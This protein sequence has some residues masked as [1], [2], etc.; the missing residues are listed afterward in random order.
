MRIA[1]V[2]TARASYAKFKTIITALVARDV[3]VQLVVCGSALLERYGACVDIVRTDFP[4]LPIT[5]CWNT[6]EGATLLT[7]AKETGALLMEL[8]VTF[9][10]LQPDLVLIM[11]D[12]HEVLAAAQA[13]SYL[14]IPLA[15][16]QGG[17]R[18]GSIDD[19]VRDCITQL[20]DWHF[21][22]TRRA[23]MRVYGLTGEAER[24]IWTGCPSVDLAK[25]ALTEPPVTREEL[26]GVY[27]ERYPANPDDPSIPLAVILF[28]P[29]T[30]EVDQAASQMRTVLSACERVAMQRIVFWPGEDAGHD[31]MSKVLREWV[32]TYDTSIWHVV[33]NLPPQRFLRLLAQAQVVIGNSSA[34]IREA[35]YLGVPVVNIGTRQA[36]RECGPQVWHTTLSHRQIISG[37]QQQIAH[38]PYLRST[39]YGSGHA[40]ERIAEVIVEQCTSHRTRKVG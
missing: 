22:C 15:H 39:L 4:T 17:E 5:E 33:R 16:C 30:T 24:I 14:H 6:Y 38:G 7:S 35:S 34:G 26:G 20:A 36:G 1:I 11:A 12:R 32:K 23:Q 28:H 9:A 18:S 3:D 40:G 10:R 37:I 25:Q 19:K 2:I 31:A 8:S 27:H 29:V 21:V 13:A